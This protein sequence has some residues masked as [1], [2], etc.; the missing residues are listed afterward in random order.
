MKY[1]ATFV[2]PLRTM[3]RRVNEG[4]LNKNQNKLVHLKKRALLLNRPRTH[5]LYVHPQV[6]NP[7]GL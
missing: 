6:K 1:N 7:S 2:L 5:K 3:G 4:Y